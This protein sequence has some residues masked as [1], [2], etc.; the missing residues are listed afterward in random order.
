MKKKGRQ[1]AIKPYEPVQKPVEKY[2]QELRARDYA[3][4][5]F[6]TEGEGA[7][8]KACVPELQRAENLVKA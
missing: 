2:F 7:L 6:L 4:Y 8:A 5:I 1:V 3:A